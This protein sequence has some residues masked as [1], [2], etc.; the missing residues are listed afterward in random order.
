M[1]Q[2]FIIEC[3]AIHHSNPYFFLKTICAGQNRVAIS[4]DCQFGCKTI[5]TIDNA[6][7][8]KAL[9]VLFF[10]HVGGRR[11]KVSSISGAIKVDVIT[12]SHIEVVLL[13]GANGKDA[14]I[15][16][17]TVVTLTING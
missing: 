14:E 10:I 16:H 7:S 12:I 3:S 11:N 13:V 2:V 5:N 15:K 9:I 6:M 8:A 4:F 17:I 1:L